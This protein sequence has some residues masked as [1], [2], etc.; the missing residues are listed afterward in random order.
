MSAPRLA[1]L[2]ILSLLALVSFQSLRNRTPEEV[3]IHEE[4]H[5]QSRS[6]ST[7]L[8]DINEVVEVNEDP[9][10]IRE[11]TDSRGHIV[12]PRIVGGTRV[13]RGRYAYFVRV[14]KNHYPACGGSLVA[15]DVVLTAGHCQM[16]LASE[17]SVVVNGYHDKHPVNADQRFRNVK[18]MKIHPD[19]VKSGGIYRNDIMLLKLDRPVYDMPIVELN[20]VVDEPRNNEEVT[21]MGL[22]ALK[23]GGGYP[24]TLQAVNVGV[25]DF[26]ECDASYANARLGPLSK[27]TMVCAGQRQGL[28]DSCQGDSGGPLVNRH[29][30]QIGVVSFGLGWYVREGTCCTIQMRI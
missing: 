4:Q 10:E 22:G 13:A 20:R 2:C 11:K 30:K 25:I 1:L 23:E 15:P 18:Q 8:H 29:G 14:D 5:H 7:D 3:E 12:T 17:L 27:D 6:L 28:R 21:V 24:D 19:Y 16:P 26:D 9:H